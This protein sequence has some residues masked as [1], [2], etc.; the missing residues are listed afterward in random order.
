M[1]LRALESGTQAAMK[2]NPL[3]RL[4]MLGQSVWLD[5]IRRAWLE[6]GTLARLIAHDGVSGLTSNPAIFERSISQ[7]PDYDDAIAAARRAGI[8]AD[9]LYEALAVDDIRRAADLLMP[10]YQT[11]GKR[12]GYVSLE[13]SPEFADQTS[14][15]IKEARRL[16]ARV[17]RPN[18]MVK[19]PGTD[20]GM[21]AVRA[22]V[23]SSINVNVTLLFSV[24]QYRRTMYAYFAGVEDAL[25]NGVAPGASVASF[26]LS[27]ID[28]HVDR[29]LDGVRAPRT[30]ALRGQAATACAR[31]AYE[32][33]RG[34]YASSYWQVLAARHVEPQR[35]LWASTSTKDQRYSDVKYLDDLVIPG[36]ITT[37]PIETLAAYRDHGT[38]VLPI[39]EKLIESHAVSGELTMLGLDLD[40]LGEQL[41]REGVRKFRTAYQQLLATLDRRIKVQQ[42]TA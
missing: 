4:A 41:Q 26:F 38:P 7:D 21:A 18:L 25:R 28:A 19:V 13:V 35:L 1:S 17:A 34:L 14:A 33:F 23:A 40:A 24:A 9:A 8:S 29:R 12:D 42:V 2:H 39:E 16:W 15:T 27:R 3:Q 31:L 11:S 37:V 5:D 32:E 6:D 36:T 20:A 30:T 10:V 22:L